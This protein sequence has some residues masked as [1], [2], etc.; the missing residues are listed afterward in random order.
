MPSRPKATH[1]AASFA[2][3][4]L[5]LPFACGGDDVSTTGAAGGSGSS[6]T[7]AVTGGSGGVSQGGAAGSEAG[8]TGGGF[9]AGGEGATRSDAACRGAADCG[10]GVCC[11]II[12][13]NMQVPTCVAGVAQC[14]GLVLCTGNDDCSNGPCCP[15]GFC[16]GCD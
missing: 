3:T 1:L 2:A 11:G 14:N 4:F 7:T 9:D 6:S 8:A 13:D 5:A 16:G 12:R 15:Q 10:T